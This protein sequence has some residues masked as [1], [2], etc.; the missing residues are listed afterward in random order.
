MNPIDTQ[1]DALRLAEALE[2]VWRTDETEGKAAAELRR[3]ADRIE[4]E[5]KGRV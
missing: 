1:P 5:A 2:Q 4:A 3:E